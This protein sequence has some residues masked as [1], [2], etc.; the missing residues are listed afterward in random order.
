MFV[1]HAMSTHVVAISPGEPAAQAARTLLER[2]ITGLPVVD[3]DG[4]VLGVVTEIDLLR[5]LRRGMDLQRT[6]VGTVM[7]PR[8][9]FVGPETDLST[10]I[11][12]MDE[13]QV[14]RL[15]VCLGSRLV[16]IVS[17]RDILAT[18]VGGGRPRRAL[19]SVG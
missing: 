13:W 10:A 17:R 12:L 15:P 19:A 5:A 14:R 1:Y 9:L 16:G 2:D 11:A 3:Q 4:Y 7:D 6:A 8:P 18:L